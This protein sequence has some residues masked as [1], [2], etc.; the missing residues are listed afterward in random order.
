[1]KHILF[2]FPAGAAG[3][4][5]VLFRLSAAVCIAS[6]GAKM[7]H[8]DTKVAALAYLISLGMMAGFPMR[9]IAVACAILAAVIASSVQIYPI[10]YSVAFIL[11]MLALAL[12]GPGAYS[13]DAF[14][15]G[16]RTVHLPG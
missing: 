11:S 12:I 15:F 7:P 3:V 10:A 1:M 14:L 5:L 8:D 6:A 2:A 13:V 9:L 4:A 16:R